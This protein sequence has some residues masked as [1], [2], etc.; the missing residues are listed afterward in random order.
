MSR[1]SGLDLSV[2]DEGIDLAEWKS[3]HG[4]GFVVIKCGGNE[5]GR[6][7]DRCFAEHVRKAKAAGLAVGCYYYTTSTTVADAVADAEHCVSLLGGMALELPVFMDVEDSGQFRLSKRALTDVIKAFCDRVQTLGYRVG[8]YT[9]GYAFNNSMYADELRRYVTWIASWQ[10]EWPSYVGQVDMWQQGTKR[11]SDGT[12]Y[13]DDV[14]GC[15]DFDWCEDYVIQNGGGEA[16]MGRLSYAEMAAEVMDH[17]IDHEAHGYSQPN[18]AGNGTTEELTL[19]D[20]SKVRVHGGDYDCSELVRMCY[21]AA[22]VLPWD[23]W[24]SYMWTG[25]EDEV[26]SSH[27]FVR[28]PVSQARRGDVLWRDGHTELHLGDGMQGGARRSETHGTTGATG[29]QDGYEIA[30]SGFDA[31]GW[32][33]CYRCALVREGQDIPTPQEKEPTYEGQDGDEMVCLIHPDDEPTMYYFDGSKM[34]P[35]AHKDEQDALQQV[36]KA[37]HGGKAMPMVKLGTKSSPF[38]K[39]LKDVLKR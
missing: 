32:A 35:L 3:R 33:R 12:V 28:V 38:G 23:Y 39:R 13:Y 37:T 17:V 26:L 20:G 7:C 27:G 9:G 22:G 24:D 34:R 15:C 36:Y 1:V 11:L 6:Y 10:A 31:S 21:A 19:S 4:I 18:R 14:S 29:D 30:R 5:G 2:W 25:N 8:L 16:P